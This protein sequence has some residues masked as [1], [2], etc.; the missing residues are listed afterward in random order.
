M[1]S[2]GVLAVSGRWRVC[3]VFLVAA[4]LS[5]A[6][7]G[8]TA[9][10]QPLRGLVLVTI[11]TLRADRL[12]CYGH[13]LPT[14][15]NIDALAAEGLLYE[16]AYA[17]TPWTPPSH[18]SIL[19]G[20]LPSEHAVRQ[21]WSDTLSGDHTTIAEVL[22]AEGFR[23][24]AFVSAVPLRKGRGFEQG[25]ELYDDPGFSDRAPFAQRAA[26]ATTVSFERW[27]ATIGEER[28]FA[29][30]HYFD[31]HA[32]Y[33]HHEA[34]D[35]VVKRDGGDLPSRD[36]RWEDAGYRYDS[37]VYNVDLQVGRLRSLLEGR[38][39]GRDTALIITSDH[40]EHFGEHG[41]ET[42]RGVYEPVLRIPL[43]VYDPRRSGESAR[44]ENVVRQVDIFPS[45]LKMVDVSAESAGS[46]RGGALTTRIRGARPPRSRG[47]RLAQR[48][49]EARY[50][51]LAARW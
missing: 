39:G 16:N 46:A 13:V 37:E 20:L 45:I 10:V 32:P 26:S 40:G 31:P 18:A 1:I 9:E 5:A 49:L 35:E 44:I 2:L 19:T 33:V 47:I 3:R 17:H 42:H 50:L 38:D 29:W 11:D 23:T 30:I 6:A 4:V 14:T 36:S 7:L 8:C 51:E 15:P 41:L 21:L 27:L 43:I 34:F 24:A 12:G 22:R 28:F 25:F 48:P